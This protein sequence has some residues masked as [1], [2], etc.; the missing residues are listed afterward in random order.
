LVISDGDPRDYP[1]DDL[2]L[3]LRARLLNSCGKATNEFE[4]LKGRHAGGRRRIVP[5]SLLFGNIRKRLVS[6]RFVAES[7]PVHLQGAL[8]AEGELPA[9]RL[10][11]D[12]V[13]ISTGGATEA[14]HGLGHVLMGRDRDVKAGGIAP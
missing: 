11:L 4:G 9:R 7:V 1:L 6:E 8:P 13:V 10:R 12:V 5:S 3:S 2:P 14:D